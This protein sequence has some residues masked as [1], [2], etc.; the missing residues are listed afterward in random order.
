MNMNIG[1]IPA[2]STIDQT[3]LDKLINLAKADKE[4]VYWQQCK[5]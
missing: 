4:K 2:I 1:L 3:N 5:T